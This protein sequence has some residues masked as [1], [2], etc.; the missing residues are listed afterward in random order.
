MCISTTLA[1]FIYAALR[2]K[3]IF[4]STG[5]KQ[6]PTAKLV[7]TNNVRVRM[8]YL[9]QP[10]ASGDVTPGPMPRRDSQMAV[11]AANGDPHTPA[12]DP[13]YRTTRQC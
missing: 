5:T 9:P 7:L 10:A 6:N 1:D 3:S 13:K 8:N 11:H 4:C 12:A 2:R